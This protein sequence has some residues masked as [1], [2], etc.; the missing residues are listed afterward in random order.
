[1]G[2][3]SPYATQLGFYTS[4][5][6]KTVKKFTSKK[7]LREALSE[8]NLQHI[9]GADIAKYYDVKGKGGKLKA[10]FIIGDVPEGSRQLL[11]IKDYTTLTGSGGFYYTQPEYKGAGRD[12]LV[13]ISRGGYRERLKSFNIF[14]DPNYVAPTPKPVAKPAPAPATP[15]NPYQSQITQLQ[16]SLSA[17]QAALNKAIADA[18][19]STK[20]YQSIIND[21]KIDFG[22]KFAAAQANYE[23][24]TQELI[25]KYGLQIGGLKTGFADQFAQQA[26]AYDTKLA[27]QASAYD[28]K[29][30][31]QAAAYDTIFANQAADFKTRFEGQEASF[32]ERLAKQQKGFDV[33]MANQSIAGRA[34]SLQIGSSQT[35][36][37]QQGGTAGFRRRPL[38]FN[39]PA[40]AGLSI[41]SGNINI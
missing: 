5:K 15:T 33:S 2:L 14:T 20:S 38:Q 29:I 25:K 30:A 35:G 11:G 28:K 37:P 31:E 3:F 34:P 40:Y 21:L 6:G 18:Q 1:M 26:S 13:R 9:S 16:S 10:G 7:D 12:G 39:T 32:V 24:Q 19:A 36:S 8:G 22:N 27:N 4:D 41:N 17:R 23:T